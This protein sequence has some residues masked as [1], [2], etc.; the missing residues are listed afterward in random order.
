MI[1]DELSG[2]ILPEKP[3]R[4]LYIAP[5]RLNSSRFMHAIEGMRISLV[6][7]DEAHAS[8]NGDMISDR[9]ISKYRTSWKP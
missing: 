1:F 7:V 4:F 3:I 5:E 6:A 9:A 8:A 2:A